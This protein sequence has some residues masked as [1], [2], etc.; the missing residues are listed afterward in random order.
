MA[1]TQIPDAVRR[2]AAADTVDEQTADT[3]AQLASLR[4]TPS[5]GEG[6]IRY[7]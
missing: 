1:P 3:T 4:Q 2:Y 7:A 5:A 6:R